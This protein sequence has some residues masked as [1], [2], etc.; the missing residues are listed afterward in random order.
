MRGIDMSEQER[1][2]MMAELVLNTGWAE[3]YFQKL[4]EE[5]LVR[6]FREKVRM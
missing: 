5:Q 2:E 1:Q 6:V 3:R 4:T